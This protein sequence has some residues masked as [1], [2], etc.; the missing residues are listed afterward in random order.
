MSHLAFDDGSGGVRARQ[1]LR[2]FDG[3]VDAGEQ[4][5]VRNAVTELGFE[6]VHAEG[7]DQ[8][9]HAR[10]E[11]AQFLVDGEQVARAAAGRDRNHDGAHER[12]RRKEVEEDLE[13]AAVGGAIRAWLGDFRGPD[14]Y[15]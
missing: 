1:D 8:R 5:G 6:A 3:L 14:D 4:C 10:E 12:I 15:D 2:L 7:H 11:R 9:S 13:Q